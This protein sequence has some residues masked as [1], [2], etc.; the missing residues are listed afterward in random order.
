MFIGQ[1]LRS[2]EKP[3]CISALTLRARARGFA[4]AGQ[5]PA[6]GKRSASVSAMASVS[7]TAKPSSS[8]STGTLP[9]GL[10]AATAR[11]K[12]ESGEK[13]KRSFSSAN[14]MPQARIST[15]GRI[16]HEE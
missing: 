2:A 14:A 4:S 6:C 3:L 9:A 13:S 12:G 7:H 5:T 8:S 10:T 15:Q 11:R 16:D 1:W